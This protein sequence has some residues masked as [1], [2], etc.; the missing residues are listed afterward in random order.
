MVQRRKNYILT[1]GKFMSRKKFLQKIIASSLAAGSLIFLPPILNFGAS[2]IEV[3]TAHA[4]ISNYTGKDIAMF[5]FGYDDAETV[6]EVKQMA[7]KRAIKA[8]Q[9]KAGVYLA[10]YSQIVN[11]NLTKDEISTVTNGISEVVEVSYEKFTFQAKDARGNLYGK[12][13]ILYEATVTVKIDTDGI[14]K[15]LD[16]NEDEKSK[17]VIQNKNTQAE[18]EEVNN[19]FEDL[20]IDAENKTPKQIKFELQQIN[21]EILA[22]EKMEEGNKLSYQGDYQG[23]LS[24]Y[25]E[26]MQISPNNKNARRSVETIYS[27]WQNSE[28][29]M[30]DYNK[31]IEQNPKNSDAYRNRGMFYFYL[32]DYE[33]AVKDFDK[34]ISLNPNKA[35]YYFD[36]GYIYYY[37]NENNQQAL[38]DFTKAIQ[39]SP[40]EAVYYM[41]RAY[42]YEALGQ[43]EKARADSKKAAELNNKN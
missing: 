7:R 13:G 1:E 15:Y 41:Y 39:L 21:A 16:R 3:A 17:L 23:A 30:A 32:S 27:Y 33:N 26:A 29:A 5:D 4:E 10:S 24:K 43:T 37:Y 20:R 2:E 9:E 11:G 14:K 28:Q 38:K 22:S 8:A 34:A 31:A 40:N 19:K 6:N 35:R 18:F 25:N 12:V 36:R 42:T